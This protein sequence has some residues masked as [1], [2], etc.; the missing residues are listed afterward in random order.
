MRSLDL[1]MFSPGTVDYHRVHADRALVSHR[2]GSAA[3]PCPCSGCGQPAKN[4]AMDNRPVPLRRLVLSALGALA[5][6]PLGATESAGLPGWPERAIH[7]IVPFD[8]GGGADLIARLL[9]RNL[10]SRLGQPVV[11]ENRA[12]AGGAV[13]THSVAQAAPDGYTLGLATQ[14]THAANPAL[15]PR[16]P[17]DPIRDFA[18]I[19]MLALVPG[20]LAV[21][22]S[23]P[24]RTMAELIAFARTRP[25]A[26]SYGTPGIG[27]LGHLLIAQMEAA[28]GLELMHVPYKSGAAA[29]VDAVAGRLHLVGESLPSALPPI[30]AGQLNALGVMAEGRVQVLPE[31]PTFAE[32]GMGEIGKPPWFGLVAPA[33]TPPPII[34]RL[35]G[36]VRSVM[37]TPEVSA[38]LA[39]S[40]SAAATGTP[41]AFARAIRATLE[42]YREVVAARGIKPES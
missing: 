38:A 25:R 1:R 35:N 24:V 26:L 27:S 6:R 16:V 21:H 42:S 36:A 18:P 2:A 9:G 22:P 10:A 30:R 37:H 20:V 32:V 33:G 4:H 39:R 23:V 7:L 34:D 5:L 17:Y 13:G 41:E 8:A 29:L 40:G 19:S 14:S 3:R 31:V 11:I 12:G 15:N 28:Y